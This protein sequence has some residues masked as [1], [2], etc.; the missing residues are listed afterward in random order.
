M[1]A[2]GFRVHTMQPRVK[3]SQKFLSIQDVSEAADSTDA[4]DEV[5]KAARELEGDLKFGS[6]TYFIDDETEAERKERELASDG[7]PYFSLEKV[8]PSERVLRF[9]IQIGRESDH[10]GLRS[11]DG[12]SEPMEKRAAVR[13]L[14]AWMIF[15]AA[16]EYAFLVSE[17]R[18]RTY[19]GELLVQWLTR[20]LQR[21]S[22]S[23]NGQGKRT[24]EP[25]LNWQLE[26]QIDGERLDGLL[27]DSDD[28]TIRLRR[29]TVTA[30]GG[31]ASHDLELVQYGLK[32]TST[33]KVLDVILKMHDRWGKGSEKSRREQAANDVVALVDA[34][35]SG[36]DF[37]DG[38]VS[39]KEKGKTQTINAETVDRLFVYPLGD[40]HLSPDEVLQEAGAV[41]KRIADGLGVQLT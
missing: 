12:T 32:K 40:K 23:V 7:L 36:L 20:T 35:V 4:Y 8:T 9:E 27:H 41:V 38:E 25:W 31:R 6:P 14:H 22:V 34:S 10:D 33:E 37:N 17:T 15:P 26:P 3:R 39:F 30:S 13:T 19:V 21:N 28:F 5:L 2:W 29:R 1:V 11:R 18:G 24:E 16:G